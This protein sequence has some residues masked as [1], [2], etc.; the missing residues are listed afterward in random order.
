MPDDSDGSRKRRV[1]LRSLVAGEVRSVALRATVITGAHRRQ[2]GIFFL[3]P[4]LWGHGWERDDADFW[5]AGQITF[6]KAAKQDFGRRGIP[7]PGSEVMALGV[8][9]N[10]SAITRLWPDY[11]QSQWHP[12]VPAV[13]APLNKAALVR[14]RDG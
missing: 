10:P 3:A 5:D 13:A 14:R 9:L 4:T 11:P 12:Q 7:I 1:L 6:W 2:N 8:R